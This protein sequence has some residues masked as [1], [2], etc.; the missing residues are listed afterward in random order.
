M[1]QERTP[2]IHFLR[3]YVIK[4]KPHCEKRTQSY[5]EHHGITTF[6]PWI[7]TP[8]HNSLKTI[9]KLKPLFPNYLFARF[10]LQHNYS[11]VKWGRGVNKIIGFGHYPTP[12]ADEALSIIKNRTDENNIVKNA[13]SLNK[14]DSV[15][16][17]RGPFK[18][19][20]G[21]FDRWETE[22]GRVK[23]LLNLVTYQPS[24]SLHYTQLDKAPS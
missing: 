24:V 23:I 14:N 8:S 18:D 1:L 5:L 11:L 10:A 4:T 12:L 21:I 20:L 7:E 19:L 2:W 17:T 9:M 15:K 3:W 13:F 16:I 6:L 22:T